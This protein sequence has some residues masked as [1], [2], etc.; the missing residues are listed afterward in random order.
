MSSLTN[1]NQHGL[2]ALS[3][4]VVRMAQ[5]RAHRQGVQF[6]QE[7][8][9]LVAEEA[10]MALDYDLGLLI[11]SNTLSQ[12]DAMA[13]ALGVNDLVVNGHRIDIRALDED[14]DVSVAR[15]LVG[16]Q[17]LSLGSLIVELDGVG[18]GRIVGHVSSG[19]WLKAEDG[20]RDADTI[21]LPFETKSDFDLSHSIVELAQ[22]APFKLPAVAQLANFENDVNDLFNNKGRLIAS[23]QKQI[24]SYLCTNWSD[25]LM[26]QVEAIGCKLPAAK[27][28][29]VLFAAGRWHAASERLTDKLA[30]RF[31]KLS[32][33]QI[34]AQILT[35]GEKLGGEIKAPAFRHELLTG[36]ATSELAMTQGM[37]AKAAQAVM[38]RVMI[39]ASAVEAVKS[40][41]KNAVA[42]DLALAIKSKRQGAAGFMAATAEE[43]GMAFQQLALQPAYATHSS[44][45]SGVDSIN[46][47]L[48]LLQATDMADIITACDQEMSQF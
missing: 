11:E 16:S 13:A 48:A 31:K 27:V 15:A 4:E 44:G 36:L 8:A 32:R 10:I 35:V 25:E 39:G 37:P 30:L 46:E 3:A 28:T 19:A 21:R 23:R 24:F 29:R 34:R 7:L 42:V 45:D 14:G 17:Y 38:A 33:D 6:R 9:R 2:I 26:A 12:S 43:I 40:L 20:L 1:Q 22:K 5:I 47:A 18:G 41:V